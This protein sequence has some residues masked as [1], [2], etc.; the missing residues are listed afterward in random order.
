MAKALS[1]PNVK[2]VTY[3]TCSIHDREN[4]LVVENVLK[5]NQDW[6]IEDAMK[7]IEGFSERSKSGTISVQPF[8]AATNGFF[9][10]LLVKK[11]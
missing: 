5:E 6:R 4:N 2:R 8:A 10:A 3:S 9:V 11:N 1:F 7:N